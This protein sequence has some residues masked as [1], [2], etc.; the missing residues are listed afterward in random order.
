M[1]EKGNGRKEKGKKKSLIIPIFWTLISD[2]SNCK[3]DIKKKCD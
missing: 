2:T 1:G 3:K